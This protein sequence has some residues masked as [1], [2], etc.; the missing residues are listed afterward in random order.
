LTQ[1]KIKNYN[2]RDQTKDICNFR[3]GS[4][5]NTGEQSKLEHHSNKALDQGL[6]NTE[7]INLLI[8]CFLENRKQEKCQKGDVATQNEE[9]TSEIA[10]KRSSRIA[11]S[12]ITYFQEKKLIK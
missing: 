8:E 7:E 2:Y 5:N 4:S 11:D 3:G 6:V 1:F 9:R 10:T 12:K